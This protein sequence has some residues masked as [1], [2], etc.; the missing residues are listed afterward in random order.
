MLVELKPAHKDPRVFRVDAVQSVV[1][2]LEAHAEPSLTSP[3][4]DFATSAPLPKRR[5]RGADKRP[6]PVVH[7]VQRLPVQAEDKPTALQLRE[8][9]A[10]LASI[11]PE[12]RAIERVQSFVFL[13]GRFDSAWQALSD[14]ASAL[15]DGLR[16]PGTSQKREGRLRMRGLEIGETVVS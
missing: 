14:R 11:D 3:R 7:L 4:V 9:S 10:A 8:L 5:R 15:L 1:T 2:G 12:L 16:A 6:G 13:D